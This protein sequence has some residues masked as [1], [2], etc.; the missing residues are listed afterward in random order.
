MHMPASLRARL[1]LVMLVA[2][3]PV[4]S[5]V[6]WQDLDDQRHAVRET[7]AAALTLAE[8]VAGDQAL[9]IDQTRLVLIALAQ[10][11]AVRRRA[12]AE[13]DAFL[14]DLLHRYSSFDN[15]SVA[16]R[17]G[18][19][20]CSGVPRTG[21]V[22]L[23]DREYFRRALETGNLAVSDF[24]VGRITGRP[25]FALA[26]PVLD[27]AGGVQGA[28]ITTVDLSRLHADLALG[29]AAASELLVLDRR[30]AVLSR[31]PSPGASSDP[32]P[33]E[34]EVA[35]A[36]LQGQHG[37]VAAAGLDGVVRLWGFAPIIVGSETVGYIA[38]GTPRATALAAAREHTVVH[39]LA[40]VLAGSLAL[41]AVWTGGDAL[42]LRQ[43][44]AIQAA[45]QRLSG[46]D[47]QARTKLPPGTDELSRL[48]H[49]FDGMAASLEQRETGLRGAEAEVRRQ[50]LHASAL[51]RVAARLNAQLDLTAV[52]QAVCEEA[53]LSLDVPIAVVMLHDPARDVLCP[54][55]GVGLPPEQWLPPVPR[56]DYR[57]WVALQTI[58]AREGLTVPGA[59]GGALHL[60]SAAGAL[61]E[62]QG[63]LI[64][65][66]NV[67]AA[68][69]VRCFSS[70]EL[71]LLQGL[72][73]QA[74][75]AIANAR[76]FTEAQRG[77]QQTQALHHIDL[78]IIGGRDLRATLGVVL[79]HVIGELGA[80][81]ATVLLLN[82]QTEILE[83]AAGTGF[84]SGALQCTRLPLGE[85]HAGR[86]A[87]EQRPV[88]IDD[89]A[90]DELTR[91]SPQLAGEGF[92]AYCAVPLL[93][94]GQVKGVLEVFSRS[95]LR[96]DGVWA[97]FLDTLATQ[98]AIAVENSSLFEERQRA[99]GDLVM[100]YDS[101]LE[102]WS[103]AL[104]L[105]DHE[106]EGHSQRVT[107]MS[108]H[109][110]RAM[111]LPETELVHLRRGALL[112]DIGKMGIPD[113]IL[114]KPGPLSE[115][116]W[117]VMRLHPVY[118]YEL[119][120][121]IAYL[122]PALDIPYCHHEKWDGTGYPRGLKGEEIPL[123][124]RIFA[125]VDVWDALRSDRPYR[126]AWPEARVRDHIRSLRGSHFDPAVVDAFLGLGLGQEAAD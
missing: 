110:A 32:S 57:E 96:R 109:L 4:L 120:H 83:Y 66:L 42:I 7:K 88:R 92:V 67:V 63:E 39:L 85:G 2:I 8:E 123:A 26:H 59:V 28:V 114:L 3:I 119:L 34:T 15:L 107:G 99:N 25:S 93:A 41:F 62:R 12:T 112:H 18:D 78:A 48:A 87:L 40:L 50:A 95:A 97:E 111:G 5:L 22:N 23:A 51:A 36:V 46:G 74:A 31:P 70:D 14:A 56:A 94:K 98:A 122:R 117:V 52:L 79:S 61:M 126:A 55:A 73:D 102:G 64:G 100:A 68:G 121:P 29:L 124:A 89:L 45:A 103:R 115:A 1:S 125:V 38:V 72:A 27:D 16:D 19:V 113:S 47:L 10:V 44:R 13:C 17:D 91:R 84:R 105:R 24:L 65:A 35:G 116:E 53:A 82:P 69:Q 20:F 71:N 21:P 76:L 90:S 49:A 60:R 58:T 30:G 6:V 106:T 86:V 75:Q 77:L 108:L 118:A 11:P 54:A 101:T 33:A 80:D 43:V 37:T 81:A 104:D 9:I